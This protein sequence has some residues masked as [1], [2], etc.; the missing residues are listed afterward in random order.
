MEVKERPVMKIGTAEK[1]NKYVLQ[2]S[3]S[4]TVKDKEVVEFC[5]KHTQIPT[6]YIK[7]AAESYCQ[8]IMHYLLM[9]YRVKVGDLGTFFLAVDTKAANTIEEAGLNQLMDIRVRFRPTKEFANEIRHA[10]VKL[11]GIF[12]LID[13]EKKIYKKV[14]PAE[15]KG[16]KKSRQKPTTDSEVAE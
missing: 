4:N 3:K 15:A 14:T 1:E 5:H 16:K 6:V 2:L 10:N 13:A 12:K 11:D 9:G 8:T 7:A